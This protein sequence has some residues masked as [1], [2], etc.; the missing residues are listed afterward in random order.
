FERFG[1]LVF[2]CNR[3][4][5]ESDHKGISKFQELR[6]GAICFLSV[7]KN[8]VGPSSPLFDQS[9]SMEHGGDERVARLRIVLLLE[10]RQGHLGRQRPAAPDFE[11]IVVYG[12][13]DGST[14]DGIVTVDQ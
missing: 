13:A 4:R 7:T 2:S 1:S 6:L 5:P 12:D 10:L 8:F 9:A 14:C 3:N 11:A